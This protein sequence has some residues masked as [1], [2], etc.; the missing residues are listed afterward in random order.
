MAPFLCRRSFWCSGSDDHVV[1]G[2][3]ILTPLNMCWKT[4][5]MTL[6]SIFVCLMVHVISID[7]RVFGYVGIDVLFVREHFKLAWVHDSVDS[8]L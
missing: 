8:I 5:N 2:E 4:L 1:S 7:V 6:E 3:K